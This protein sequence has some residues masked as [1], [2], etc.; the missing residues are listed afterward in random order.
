M[1]T[2]ARLYTRSLIGLRLPAYRTEPHAWQAASDATAG[3]RYCAKWRGLEKHTN[4]VFSNSSLLDEPSTFPRTR[5]SQ[6]QITLITGSLIVTEV[7]RRR[8]GAAA[9]HS[10]RHT[11][12]RDCDRRP[13]PR[14]DDHRRSAARSPVVPLLHPSRASSTSSSSHSAVEVAIHRHNEKREGQRLVRERPRRG[15]ALDGRPSGQRACR[16]VGQSIGVCYWCIPPTGDISGGSSL[17]TNPSP[18]V[19]NQKVL[20]SRQSLLLHRSLFTCQR[21]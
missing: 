21:H 14:A 4:F 17:F 5:G 2:T 15:A 11:L 10:T 12:A 3:A 16:G 9:G 18:D 8:S 19:Y 7:L 13:R 20:K 6:P 1:V